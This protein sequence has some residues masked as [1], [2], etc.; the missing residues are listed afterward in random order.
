LL[1]KSQQGSL[2]EFACQGSQCA[3]EHVRFVEENNGKIFWLREIRRRR[4]VSRT[5]IREAVTQAGQCFQEI[6]ESFSESDAIF[7]SFD[8]DSISCAVC[9]GVSCPSVDG[10][11]TAEEAL[12]IAFLAG[13]EE[14][15][16]AFDLSEYNPAVED[17]RTGRLLSNVFYYFCLGVALRKEV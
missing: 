8:A 10:G 13:K 11:L 7:V 14:R 6:L 2:I 12:E 16:K 9:P 4:V 17:F 1:Y 5:G 3:A 15:V